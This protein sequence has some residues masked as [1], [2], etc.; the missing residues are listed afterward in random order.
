[1]I[2]EDNGMAGRPAFGEE[3]LTPRERLERFADKEK[4]VAWLD[5]RLPSKL[6]RYRL[7]VGGEDGVRK[8]AALEEA[9]RLGWLKKPAEDD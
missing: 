2:D 1:V 3:A 8:R 4:S 7:K 9:R 5:R 6:A